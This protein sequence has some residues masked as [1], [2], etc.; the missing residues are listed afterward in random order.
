MGGDLP[1][2]FQPARKVNPVERRLADV[3]KARRLI[4]F[5]AAVPLE[6]GLD[7]LAAWWKAQQ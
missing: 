6:E 4:G 2:E 1:P 3:E 7:R 5:E